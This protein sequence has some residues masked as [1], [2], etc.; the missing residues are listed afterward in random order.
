M[1]LAKFT[2]YKYGPNTINTRSDITPFFVYL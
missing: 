2:I 1:N